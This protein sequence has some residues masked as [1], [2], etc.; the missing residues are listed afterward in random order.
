MAFEPGEPRDW[1]RI[2]A[3][4]KYRH[5]PSR[6]K[7]F[8]CADDARAITSRVVGIGRDITQIHHAPRL[9]IRPEQR[10]LQIE[11]DLSQLTTEFRGCSTQRHWRR[12]RMA[13]TIR[14][15]GRA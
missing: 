10:C 9:A 1:Y 3:P 14:L 4:Q 5:S 11:V 6:Q 12:R 7:F 13:G 15:V 2:I 8:G